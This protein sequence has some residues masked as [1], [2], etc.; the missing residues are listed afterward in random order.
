MQSYSF[1]KNARE[2]YEKLS[3]MHNNMV[4]LY[5]NLG[6]Y[7]I[8][9]PNTITIED[10]F[11][12]LNNFRNLFLVSN[13]FWNMV[14][15][16]DWFL[17]TCIDIFIHLMTV[18]IPCYRPLS[19]ARRSTAILFVIWDVFLSPKQLFVKWDS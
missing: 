12:D 7:F 2:Q 4:K 15:P 1:T 19:P 14:S 5:E 18:L 16:V 17:K 3:T 6:E 13:V 9:D 10:F 8:F 11:G